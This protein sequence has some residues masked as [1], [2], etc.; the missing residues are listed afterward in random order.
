MVDLRFC[1]GLAVK[2]RP[3]VLAQRLKSLLLSALPPTRTH[4]HSHG[5]SMVGSITPRPALV[6][7]TSLAP[8]SRRSGRHST[9]G[10]RSRPSMRLVMAPDEIIAEGSLEC[11]RS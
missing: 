5:A 7:P 6:R 1:H 9:D 4:L 11:L 2:A 10:A 8:R 3:S